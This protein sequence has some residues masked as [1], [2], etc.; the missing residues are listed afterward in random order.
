MR[1]IPPFLAAL[2]IPVFDEPPKH[3]N[4]V[5]C[6]TPHLL[7]TG[8]EVAATGIVVEQLAMPRTKT[9]AQANFIA[10][11]IMRKNINWLIKR[12]YGFSYSLQKYLLGLTRS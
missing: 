3:R 7:P 6:A 2:L 8:F 4:E 1:V 10:F 12:G 9:M 5:D 11:F